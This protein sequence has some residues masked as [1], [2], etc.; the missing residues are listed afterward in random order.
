[1][2]HSEVDFS[3][4]VYSNAAKGELKKDFPSFFS[5]LFADTFESVKSA[6]G[7]S[8]LAQTVK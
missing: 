8:T 6:A 2:T 3:I 1:M 4:Q 7:S 5:D